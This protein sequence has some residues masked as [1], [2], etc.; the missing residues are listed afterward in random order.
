MSPG[1]AALSSSLG[2][3]P[4]ELENAGYGG[5]GVGSHTA[6]DSSMLWNSTYGARAE[7]QGQSR[8]PRAED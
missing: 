2:L 4:M 7:D 3:R 8:G 1:P 6:S 5:G